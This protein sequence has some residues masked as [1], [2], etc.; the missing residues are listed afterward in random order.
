[1]ADLEKHSISQALSTERTAAQERLNARLDEVMTEPIVWPYPDDVTLVATDTSF[2]HR[3]IGEAASQGK[4]IVLFY[5]DGDEV[6]L[7]PERPSDRADRPWKDDPI[8]EG[9]RHE[10]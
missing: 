7:R 8:A 10:K 1:M 9:L 3:E 2:A 4:A 6:V 5:P